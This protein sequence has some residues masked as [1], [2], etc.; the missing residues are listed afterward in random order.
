[1]GR[2]VLGDETFIL[3]VAH[4]EVQRLD[5]V[6]AGNVR[7]PGAVFVGRVLADALDIH[8]HRESQRIRIDAAVIG[9]VGSRLEHHVGMAL[10]E[11]QHEA[12]AD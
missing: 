7:E 12:I 9:A 5:P 3:E 4:G 11:F 8:H 2:Q 6:A 10:Q 1:L